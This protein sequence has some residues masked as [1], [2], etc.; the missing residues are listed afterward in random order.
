[1]TTGA[2]ISTIVIW[3]I[4]LGGLGICFSRLGK[5]GGWED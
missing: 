5:G 3:L 4:L 1:M 2:I